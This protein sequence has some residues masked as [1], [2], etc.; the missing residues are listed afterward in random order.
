MNLL[1]I[2]FFQGIQE[3][4]G[5]R[6]RPEDEETVIHFIKAIESSFDDVRSESKLETTLSDLNIIAPLE[7]C[8][9]YETFEKQRGPRKKRRNRGEVSRQVFDVDG[10]EA[11]GQVFDVDE[12]TLQKRSHDFVDSEENDEEE[13]EE[14]RKNN[15]SSIIK[16]DDM[17][18][19]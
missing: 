7:K 8:E 16:G 18:I 6:V 13:I 5:S 3:I 19:I 2:G 11:S 12:R 4:F 1:T 17:D 9:V 10:G 14:H 15:G